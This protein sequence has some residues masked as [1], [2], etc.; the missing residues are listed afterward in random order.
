MNITPRKI[1]DTE[2]GKRPRSYRWVIPIISYLCV[3]ILLIFFDKQ[4]YNWTQQIYTPL[5]SL[6]VQKLRPFGHLGICGGIGVLLYVLGWIFTKQHW[7]RAG[8]SVLLSIALTAA[9]IGILKPA[10]GR[11]EHFG[12][13]PGWSIS[14]SYHLE[15]RWGRFPSGDDSMAFATAGAL[16]IEFPAAAIVCYAVAG[17]VGFERVYVG[18]HFA[19]D[20][21]AAAWIGI[22]VAR[23]VTR[24]KEKGE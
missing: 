8:V 24:R 14:H 18:S 1:Q 19:S 20:V 21:F 3:L 22:L 7:K 15:D 12:N 9:I 17:L 6:V 5:L 10:I 4:I 2:S 23:L 11:T 16:A 13:N